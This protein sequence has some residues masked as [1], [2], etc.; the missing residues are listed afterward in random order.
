MAESRET[1]TSQ[2]EV[3]RLV[4]EWQY[5]QNLAEALKQRIDVALAAISEIENTIQAI[6]ELGKVTGEVEALFV[7][8]ANAYAKGKIT[9]SK[10]VLINV[11]ANVLIEKSLDDAKKFLE[12]RIDALKRVVTETQQQLASVSARISK[13]EPELRRIAESQAEAQA[14]GKK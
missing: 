1:S 12:T 13:L 6:D 4:A 3:S 7:L 11:G 9:D 14:G 2:E 10:R 5:L 8:G